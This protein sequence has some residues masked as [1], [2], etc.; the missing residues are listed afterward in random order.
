VPRDTQNVSQ[1]EAQVLHHLVTPDVIQALDAVVARAD[2][3]GQLESLTFRELRN[4]IEH[5]LDMEKD[6]GLVV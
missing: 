1:A 2:A 4:Q 3:S 5:E 6:A